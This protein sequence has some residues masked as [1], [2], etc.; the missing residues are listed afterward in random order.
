MRHELLLCTV[1]ALLAAA[2]P[3]TPPNGVEGGNGWHFAGLPWNTSSA[4]VITAPGKG[5]SC[6]GKTTANCTHPTNN[7]DVNVAFHTTAA[8]EEFEVSFDFTIS[9]PFTAAGLVF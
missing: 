4:G 1:L 2:D 8:Y 7:S 9:V 3:V 6:G 5:P